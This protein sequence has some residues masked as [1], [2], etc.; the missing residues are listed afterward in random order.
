MRRA[1]DGAHDNSVEEHAE[2]ALLLGHLADPIRKPEAAE[3]MVRCARRNRVRRAARLEHR[4]EGAL[5]AVANPDVETRLLHAD[6]ASHN[7]GQLDV[8]D[9]LEARVVA[10]DP[11]LLHGR[12]A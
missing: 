3:R 11:E 5:P 7:P 2:L 12:Y 9:D 8:A 4:I 10:V 6:I 1:R